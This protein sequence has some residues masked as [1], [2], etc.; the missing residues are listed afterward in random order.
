MDLARQCGLLI[1]ADDSRGDGR[2][3][4][5]VL[6][7]MPETVPEASF[8]SAQHLRNWQSSALALEMR[9]IEESLNHLGSPIYCNSESAKVF[10][11]SSGT[12][13]SK[14]IIRVVT[15]Q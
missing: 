2:G 15:Q 8:T 4:L 5:S 6:Y 7:R 13:T 1:S 10:G 11:A 3:W 9:W 14:S 12:G